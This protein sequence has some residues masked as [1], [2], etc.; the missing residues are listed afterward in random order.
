MRSSILQFVRVLLPAVLLVPAG[1]SSSG[2]GSG[3]A[4]SDASTGGTGGGEVSC[5]TA[6]CGGDVVGSWT[7]NDYCAPSGISGV[8]NDTIEFKSDGTY[9][10]GGSNG[11]WSVSGTTLTT[12]GVS[13]EYCVHGATLV[14]KTGTQ[15]GTLTKIRL[16]TQ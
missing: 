13:G 9:T 1:C 14:T 16:R 5:D 8:P 4:L 2:S 7:L 15:Y 10:L 11:T 6:P 12:N 3:G